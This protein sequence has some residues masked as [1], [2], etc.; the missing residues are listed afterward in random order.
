MNPCT[1]VAR[2]ALAA[3]VL[4]VAACSLTPRASPDRDAAA[5][6]FQAPGNAATIYVYRSRFNHTDFDSLL[7]IDGRLI[8]RTLPGS[9][10]RIDTVP[11]RH[12]LHGSG[13]D[14]GEYALNARPGQVYFVSLDVL[15]GHSRFEGVPGNTAQ[16]R[17][18]ACC[19]L[20]ENW[21]PNQRPF[22]R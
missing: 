20:L 12:V 18:R 5:K 8:G 17:V 6:E 10:F 3:L 15:G 4:L 21:A 14:L 13:V 1:L 19:A 2:L 9:Y 22:V 11:A 16:E 7:Y